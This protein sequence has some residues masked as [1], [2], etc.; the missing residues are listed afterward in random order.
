MLVN[1]PYLGEQM[2]NLRNRRALLRRY[3][4][5]SL[6][7]L[8]DAYSSVS[9]FHFRSILQVN[10]SQRVRI[11]LDGRNT[12]LPY[13]DHRYTTEYPFPHTHGSTN[14]FIKRRTESLGVRNPAALPSQ[15]YR[16]LNVHDTSHSG[17]VESNDIFSYYQ[18][19]RM[20]YADYYFEFHRNTFNR[21]L[22][23]FLE[24]QVHGITSDE[25]D[26]YEGPIPF[27]VV[28]EEI[29]AIVYNDTAYH[30]YLSM[31]THGELIVRSQ[32]WA[33]R[34]NF[35]SYNIFRE[36][37][38][39]MFLRTHIRHSI[40]RTSTATNST[41]TT[42]TTINSGITSTTLKYEESK[43]GKGNF[44]KTVAGKCFPTRRKP[45]HGDSYHYG[46]A[47]TTGHEN[48]RSL[49][50]KEF[51]N[52][53]DESSMFLKTLGIGLTAFSGVYV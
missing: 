30:D 48:F 50:H 31:R 7:I 22:L 17:R 12:L 36:E 24:L 21:I 37:D 19:H 52:I 41:T 35:G 16:V 18:R 43:K 44:F 39:I 32:R 26:T 9:R 49:C 33:C 28:P 1:W 47:D 25:D 53:N 3:A 40:C 8:E 6:S 51:G 5:E 2:L 14:V 20:T 13:I 34:R 45:S 15:V 27:D 46:Q 4:E 10:W 23:F 29:Q 11:F 38:L 42:T